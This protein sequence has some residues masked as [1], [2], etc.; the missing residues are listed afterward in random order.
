[1]LRISAVSAA[2]CWR[3]SAARRLSAARNRD[4]GITVV[5]ARESNEGLRRGGWRI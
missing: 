3:A 4:I 1:M 2:L 5:A